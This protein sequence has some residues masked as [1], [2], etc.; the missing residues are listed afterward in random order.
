MQGRI[1]GGG[2]KGGSP[3]KIFSIPRSRYFMSNQSNK[4]VTVLEQC[5]VNYIRISMY[6]ISYKCVVGE[7]SSYCQLAVT[8]FFF[9]LV[10]PYQT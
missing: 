7:V 4:A 6:F 1:R 5:V 3:P 2:V 9:F 8:F 10:S